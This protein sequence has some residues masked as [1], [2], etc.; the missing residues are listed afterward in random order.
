MWV[1][2]PGRLSEQMEH[3]CLR[4]GRCA[5][6]ARQHGYQLVVVQELKISVS[7]TSGIPGQAG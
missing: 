3:Q 5:L 7:M 1:Y 6:T 2:I 4:S